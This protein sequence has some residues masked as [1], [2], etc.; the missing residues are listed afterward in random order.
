MA[1][2]FVVTSRL[3]VDPASRMVAGNPNDSDSFAWMMRYTALAISHGELPALVTKAMN[4]PVGISMMW[5]NA[6][7]V[8]G[9][10]L[11]PVTLWLGPQVSLNL[12]L[13]F[14]FAG[15]AAAMLVALRHWGVSLPGSALGGV[16]YGFSPAL[17]H[18]AI[19]HYNL[20]FMVLPPLI[21]DIALRLC[22]RRAQ[23]VGGG[24]LLGVLVAA[25]LY[26]S[27]E[28]L[29]TTALA[30][31]L[32]LVVLALSRPR[33]VPRL[34]R[35]AAS[36]LGIA[37]G[38][39]LLLAGRG[40]WIEFVGP[41]HEHGSAFL[42]D[43]YKNDVTGFITPSGSLLF[44]TAGAAAQAARY[45]GG[46]P[47]YL[48]YLGVPL[49]IVLAGTAVLGWRRLQVRAVAVC[50]I[51]LELLSLGAHPLVSGTVHPGAI[52]PWQW[53]GHLPLISAVL[54]DRLSLVADGAAGALIAFAFDMALSAVRRNADAS[55]ARTIALAGALVTAVSVVPLIPLPLRTEPTA[56]LPAGWTAAFVSLHLS[57]GAR[58]LAVP[59]PTATLTDAM[60]WQ[61][62][63]GERI[64]LNAG[65]FEGPASNGQAYVEGGGLPPLAYY[66]DNLWT[67]SAPGPAPTPAEAAAALSGWNPT[68]VVAVVGNR[69]ALK[70][71]LTAILG[72]PSFTRGQVLVW[73][74]HRAAS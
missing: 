63:S 60:R 15:S 34:L 32:I 41:L 30:T 56:G 40:L 18:S 53:I 62:E 52:L 35:P 7:L 50:L 1:G 12:L 4:A 9:I 70:S 73:R 16:V 42:F 20:Q 72:Q 58:V 57:P 28:V 47:E 43:F 8:P 74:M 31:I 59:V 55:R 22:L 68:A 11:T 65:Y 71:Y 6:M 39:W 37:V 51:A 17:L 2:A 45:Q 33:A 46:P 14:G 19:G 66:L 25:Q 38:T 54:P 5:N 13:T 44:H 61:A 26:I 27:S 24:L 64:S 67:G 48:A 3:W 36:G 49:I 23:P 69:P 10:I 21:A 29:L